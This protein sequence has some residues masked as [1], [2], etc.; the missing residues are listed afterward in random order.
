LSYISRSFGSTLLTGIG[1][2][3]SVGRHETLPP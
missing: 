2:G 3:W 1:E